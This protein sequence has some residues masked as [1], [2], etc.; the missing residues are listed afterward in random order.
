MRL[1]GRRRWQEQFLS[2]N[3]EEEW[4]QERHVSSQL[5]SAIVIIIPIVGKQAH[6][7]IHQDNP[8]RCCIFD[9]ASI[10]GLGASNARRR[11]EQRGRRRQQ[12]R[13]PDF[14]AGQ[15]GI[16]LG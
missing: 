13:P 7:G 11:L 6:L 1:Q 16:I 15:P 12:T 2:T 10:F 14:A 8:G 4:Q 9:D 5:S 3:W